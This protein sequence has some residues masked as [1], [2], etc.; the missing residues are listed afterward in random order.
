MRRC[1]IVDDSQV[2]RKV[3][4]RI[5]SDEGF[6]VGEA[7]S[8]AEALEICQEE[9]PEIILVD[10]LLPDVDSIDLIARIVSIEAEIAPAI[11]YS[12]HQIQLSQIMKAK[13]AGAKGHILKPFVRQ[14]LLE[15]LRAFEDLFQK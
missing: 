9:M 12:T 2:I 14:Q 3:V 4:R 1:L 11:L 15:Q 13:R 6:L 7:A 8:G 10:S 5:L